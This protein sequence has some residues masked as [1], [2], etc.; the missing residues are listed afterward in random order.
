MKIKFEVK[1]TPHAQATYTIF[2][3]QKGE[4]NL[5]LLITKFNLRNLKIGE[6]SNSVQKSDVP[7]NDGLLSMN[8]ANLKGFI[9]ALQLM[10]KVLPK[11]KIK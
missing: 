8:G 10:A 3:E 9:G 6:D 2:L 7:I 11:K 1:S 4:D 5:Q